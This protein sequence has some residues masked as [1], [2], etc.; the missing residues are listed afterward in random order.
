MQEEVAMGDLGGKPGAAQPPGAPRPAPLDI[1]I[2]VR[3]GAE[4]QGRLAVRATTHGGETRRFRLLACCHSAL[5][6]RMRPQNVRPALCT[7]GRCKWAG[8]DVHRLAVV[9]TLAATRS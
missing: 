6:A 7:V 2:M 8:G 4:G 5:P 1:V 9:F 3:G